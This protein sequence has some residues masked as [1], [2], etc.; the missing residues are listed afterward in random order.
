MS[1]L[2]LKVKKSRHN[3]N[4]MMFEIT[5]KLYLFYFICEIKFKYFLYTTAKMSLEKETKKVRMN[6]PISFVCF[7]TFYYP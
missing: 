4:I 6:V 3:L 7:L 5:C 2:S 1:N